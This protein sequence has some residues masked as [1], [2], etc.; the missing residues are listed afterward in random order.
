MFEAKKHS[1]QGS[2]HS[3]VLG[4]FGSW[5]KVPSPILHRLEILERFCPNFSGRRF[6]KLAAGFRGRLL[7]NHS[8][9]S[10]QLR[11]NAT[12]AQAP[13][14]GQRR[15]RGTSLTSSQT[16]P[17]T[18]PT[19][20]SFDLPPSKLAKALPAYQI[21]LNR[22]SKPSAK[23][24]KQNPT[25]D[26]TPKSF[27]R[28][29]QWHTQGKRLRPGL[30]EGKPTGKKRKPS[31]SIEP[32][33]KSDTLAAAA[34]TIQPGER[35]S[36][37]G[38]RVDQA[39]PLAHLRQTEKQTSVKIPGVR[40]TVL[41]KHNKRLARM[42]REW[43]AEE[44]RRR[45]RREDE[46]EEDEEE[47]EETEMLWEGVKVQGKR[48]GRGGD[49][50]EDPWQALEGKRKEARQRNLQ[51]VVKA[52]PQL[53]RVDSKFSREDGG[54]GVGVDVRDVPGSVG[55]LRKREEVGEARRATID[56]YREMMKGRAVK[57]V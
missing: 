13:R 51:D 8:S 30:D 1:S 26:D 20:N 56:A 40:E 52:P 14:Q 22:A 21:R 32:P 6:T 53:K 47:R 31:E 17:L 33:A 46:D 25:K 5:G 55:S 15:V 50:E 2:D 35:L 11:K 41:T 19:T 23:P 4:F 27:A 48:K 29:M 18:Y 9:L 24:G 54:M 3:V 42:Q 10:N 12:Q 43:R 16:P 34:P 49:V 36:D 39:L 37:F 7:H 28:L 38:A 44:Q 57:A 45:E